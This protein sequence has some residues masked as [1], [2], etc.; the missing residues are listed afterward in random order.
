MN[1]ATGLV[2]GLLS[3]SSLMT[4]SIAVAEGPSFM[5]AVGAALGEFG[6][7]AGVSAGSAMYD[8]DRLYGVSGVDDKDVGFK[9]YL[10]LSVTKNIDVE[11]SYMDLGE[12]SASGTVGG[13]P[14]RANADLNLFS[15]A[16][17]FNFPV[18]NQFTLFGKLGAFHSDVDSAANVRNVEFQASD[19][20]YNL[21]VGLGAKYAFNKNLGARLEWE[22]F[23]K[24]GFA[25]TTG[26]FDV[27]FVSLGVFYK[28]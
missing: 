15:L 17:V 3:I 11:F 9:G 4:P 14:A 2:A 25:G 21:T 19:N 27:D 18:S 16:G 10:G 13:I 28:F 12:I 1:K 26:D 5:D 20:E 23:N 6:I 7:F 22:R 24:V 8:I